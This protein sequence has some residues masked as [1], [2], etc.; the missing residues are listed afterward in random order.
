MDKKGQFY[1]LMTIIIVGLI[2][3]FA[4]VI[5]FSQK[6]SSVNF[7]YLKDELIIESENVMDDVLF[8]NKNMNESLIDFSK[9]YSTYSEADNLY[10]IFGNRE[11]VTVAGYLKLSDG[12]IF[13]DAGS[14]NQELSFSKNVYNSRDFINPDRNIKVTVNNVV[15]DF[16]LSLG[17]NFYFILS[18]EVKEDVY[19]VT[20]AYSN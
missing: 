6:K 2:F 9:T 15:Y 5:N 17:E 13:V 1:L 20:N 12:K 3:S 8:N 11:L 14:G 10:Y 18:K 19:I 16:S 7:D 4:A